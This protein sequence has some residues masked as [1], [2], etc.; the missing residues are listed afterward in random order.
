MIPIV[1]ILFDAGPILRGEPIEGLLPIQETLENSIHLRNFLELYPPCFILET[2]FVSIFLSTHSALE[3]LLDRLEDEEHYEALRLATHQPTLLHDLN[4][5]TEAVS[6]AVQA[7]LK[8]VLRPHG[9]DLEYSHY[10]VK[11][12]R[13]STLVELTYYK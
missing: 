8:N 5:Y 9:M 10:V 13:S 6:I 1:R 2:V 12:W 4:L 11:E 7:I 3:D